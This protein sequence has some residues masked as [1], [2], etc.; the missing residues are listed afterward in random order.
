MEPQVSEAEIKRAKHLHSI[1]LFDFIVIHIFLFILSLSMI[2]TTYVPL[3]LMAIISVAALGYVMVKASG[4]VS[5]EPSRFV[6]CHML[7][8]AK[9]AR[10]FLLLFIVTGS[11]SAFIYFGGSQLGMKTPTIYAL[12]GGIGQLPFM[13]ALLTLV[14]MEYDAEHQGKSGKIPAAG[15]KLQPA[16]T[17]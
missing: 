5:R 16:D 8:A 3:I 2:K 4:S 7:L 10:M 13:V 1:L 11:F 14:V 9:R 12:A 15:Q 17:Q 6:R